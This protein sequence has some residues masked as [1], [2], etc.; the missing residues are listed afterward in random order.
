VFV[1]YEA[2]SVPCDIDLV[3]VGAFNGEHVDAGEAME[4]N[5]SVKPTH[6]DVR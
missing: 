1:A 3:L 6:F 5:S 2:L 4:L